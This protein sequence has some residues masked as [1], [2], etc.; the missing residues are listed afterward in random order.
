MKQYLSHVVRTLA[1]LVVIAFPGLAA[2][3]QNTTAGSLAGTIL[4]ASG[5]ALPGAKVLVT[6]QG[7]K[8]AHTA[9]TTSTGFYSVENLADGDYTLSVTATGFKQSNVTDIHLD[10]G[11]R[12]GQD[13][14]LSVGSVEAKVDV[15][16]SAIAVQTESAESGGTISAKEVA[17][18]MLNG[19]NFH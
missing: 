11:Q 3:A 5:A 10:P 19:R 17:N 8:E 7:T 12:R 6:N 16:A 15:E 2:N 4:D 14:K 13:V 9:V 18:L 1:M